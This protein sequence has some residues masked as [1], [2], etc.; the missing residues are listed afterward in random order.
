MDLKQREQV[1]AR[2]K[3]GQVRALVNVDI[4]TTGFDHPPIDL[5]ALVRPTKSP[6]L[7]IQMLGRGMRTVKNGDKKDCLVL[8]FAQNIK[9]NGGIYDIDGSKKPKKKSISKAKKKKEE[10]MVEEIIQ[11]SINLEDLTEKPSEYSALEQLFTVSDFE[12]KV[13]NSK[14]DNPQFVIIWRYSLPGCQW[15]TESVLEYRVIKSQKEN[16]F[17]YFKE[18]WKLNE[19]RE[20]APRNLKEAKKKISELKIFFGK[21]KFIKIGRS[22]NDFPVVD[23]YDRYKLPIYTERAMENAVRMVKAAQEQGEKR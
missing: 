23:K 7:H 2:F 1:I 18:W 5:I 13:K 21:V 4:L 6:G 10:E 15:L 11:R 20:P 8:D 9:R 22:R 19:G 12:I 17:K 14:N 3:S 16:T